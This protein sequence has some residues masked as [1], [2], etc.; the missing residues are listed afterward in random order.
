MI[1]KQSCYLKKHC[2]IWT[3]EK[4]SGRLSRH[5]RKEDH[6]F[7]SYGKCIQSFLR[8]VINWY[9]C[10]SNFTVFGII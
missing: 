7:E 2:C 9:M 1:S 8:L 5:S 3:P 4:L 6:G 10:A